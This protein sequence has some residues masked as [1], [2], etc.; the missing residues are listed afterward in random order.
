M[1]TLPPKDEEG[2]TLPSCFCS[3]TINHCHFTVHLVLCVGIPLLSD[4]G[5]LF[6]MTP[7]HTAEALSSASAQEGCNVPYEANMCYL[8]SF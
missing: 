1:C 2:D 4:G 5:Y 8:S 6:Q 3:Y 7:K